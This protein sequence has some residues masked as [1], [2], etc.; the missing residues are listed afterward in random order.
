MFALALLPWAHRSWSE[1]E[2]RVGLKQ[3]PP[4]HDEGLSRPD[5]EKLESSDDSLHSEVQD[6]QSASG[7]ELLRT[8][9]SKARDLVSNRL[10]D[11]RGD[12]VD[13]Q[14]WEKIEE[15]LILADVGVHT[16]MEI[17]T[18]LRTTV[19]EQG[20]SEGTMVLD[21]LKSQMLSELSGNRA[22]RT[23]APKGRVPIWLFVGVNGVGKTTSIGKVSRR[24]TDE[25]LKVLLAAG[26]TF[27]AA[28]AEQLEQWAAASDAELVR[29]SEG[30][31]PS[32]VIYDASEAASARE[33]DL[34]L[35]DTAGRLHNKVNLMEELAKVRRVADREPGEVCEVLLVIDATTGQNG[36][37]QARE[38]ADAVNVTGV[39]LTK[40]DGSA[41]GG[42]VFAIEKELGLPV[43]LVG[44]GEGDRDLVD[45]D[46]D[47]FVE[48][49]FG[50]E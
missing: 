32:S 47:L 44:L 34:V 30:A 18:R 14:I 35:A 38:F 17:V 50:N 31:D 7:T 4:N 45:F 42:I 46:P 40:L 10:K 27:R 28:A 3:S 5:L 19:E 37:S 49:L 13:L 41:K 25:G 24:Y 39:V 26:D 16:T 36:L 6:Q 33:V 11:I 29:G 1:R 12:S 15:L 2:G 20:V 8:R 43:K 21:Q 23:V 48:A 9:I 22:L